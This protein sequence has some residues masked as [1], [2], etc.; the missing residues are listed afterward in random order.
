MIS[1]H[2]SGM[3]CPSVPYR[4][5]ARTADEIGNTSKPRFFNWKFGQ[6]VPSLDIY[7]NAMLACCDAIVMLQNNSYSER[8]SR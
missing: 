3:K 5:D 1:T 6:I 7:L 2:Y 8:L 4:G